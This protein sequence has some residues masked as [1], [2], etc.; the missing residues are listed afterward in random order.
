MKKIQ[1]F[2]ILFIAIL[3][4]ACSEEEKDS[5]KID[6]QNDADIVAGALRFQLI[7]AA[8]YY[9]SGVS[10]WNDERVDGYTSGYAIVN[11]A[12]EKT[13]SWDLSTYEYK[14]VYIECFLYCTDDFYPAL[15]G[16]ATLDGYI[17]YRDNRYPKYSGSWILKGSME[18]SG[19]LK[20]QITFELVLKEKGFRWYGVIKSDETIWDVSSD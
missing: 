10:I 20:G 19:K 15:T 4:H 11:G 12:Y 8:P 5:K 6:S 16:T 3:L 18:L 9:S 2:L 7:D 17:S 1:F 14:D 13:Y